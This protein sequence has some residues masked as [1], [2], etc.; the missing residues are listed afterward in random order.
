MT[1][2]TEISLANEERRDA[3]R[4][5]A[6]GSRIEVECA[7]HALQEGTLIDVSRSGL[8]F[9]SIHLFP[10]GSTV[11]VHPP[12]GADLNVCEARIMRQSVIRGSEPAAFEYGLQFTK[13]VGTERHA[14]FLRLRRRNS[15]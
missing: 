6:N 1:T 13:S 3:L 9:R 10:C 5:P 8:R 12:Q 15:G 7:G 4:Q 2:S 11:K 14:W